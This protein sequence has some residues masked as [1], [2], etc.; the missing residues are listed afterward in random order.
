[1]ERVDEDK[2]AVTRDIGKKRQ[3]VQR[4]RGICGGGEG[5]RKRTNPK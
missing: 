1:M 4:D 2:F 5:V 3:L